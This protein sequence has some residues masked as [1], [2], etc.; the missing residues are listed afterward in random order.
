MN[1]TNSCAALA[2][3]FFGTLQS[4]GAITIP[5]A[6]DSD[7]ALNITADTVI[8]LSQALT[9]AWDASNTANAGKV[10]TTLAS[11]PLSS[12]SP[13]SRSPLGRR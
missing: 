13:M 4:Q 3:L 10:S 11:G 8:D 6:D 2:L 1:L 9:G 7:G 12:N 5:A